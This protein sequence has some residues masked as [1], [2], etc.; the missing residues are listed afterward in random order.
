M[1]AYEPVQILFVS[2]SPSKVNAVL[3]GLQG[4]CRL[5][6]RIR[7]VRNA[8]EALDFLLSQHR[9]VPEI[10]RAQPS[11]VLLDASTPAAERDQLERAIC[12]HARIKQTSVVQ[13]R[14][15]T[16]QQDAGL[17]REAY[18]K[19]PI[20][21]EAFHDAV[22]ALNDNPFGAKRP[23]KLRLGWMVVMEPCRPEPHL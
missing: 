9:F 16:P 3:K 6:N 23:G 19:Q 12:A 5:T 13:L 7:V 18:M 11:M 8:T 1:T 14:A 17:K 22:N 21:P 2:Q 4:G 10:E 20:T 15:P